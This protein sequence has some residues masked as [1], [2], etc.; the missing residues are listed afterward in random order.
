IRYKNVMDHLSDAFENKRTQSPFFITQANLTNVFAL[1]T[2]SLRSTLR[3]LVP[4]EPGLLT[5]ALAAEAEEH[6]LLTA[7][8]VDSEKYVSKAAG[9][10]A[11]SAFGEELQA[12]RLSHPLLLLYECDVRFSKDEVYPF[13]KTIGRWLE[14]RTDGILAEVEYTTERVTSQEKR[15]SNNP[16]RLA[17]V[18]DE[19]D[20][21][22]VLKE[23]SV[24]A[25]ISV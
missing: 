14:K 19:Y 20:Y 21:V 13:G 22:N 12:A 10:A 23:V 3:A 18:W 15:L 17:F 2:P 25:R 8:R 4:A 7:V 11:I 5:S 6:P 1:I 24:L 16:L 9:L